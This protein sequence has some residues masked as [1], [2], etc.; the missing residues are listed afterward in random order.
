MSQER[1]D[2]LER[3]VADPADII[4]TPGTES[5]V[6]EIYDA[7]AE[8][9]RDPAN[10]DPQP[11]LRVRQPPRPL[12]CAPG[13]RSSA[14]SSTLRA[15][16]PRP[17]AR[18]PSSR[19]PARPARIARRRLPEGAARHADRRRRGARVPDD[20]RERLRRAQHPGHRRQAHPADP[21]RDEHR[22]R[23]RRVATGPP[24]SSTCCSTRD[25]GR[26]YLADR[27]RSTADV[28]D[29]LDALRALVDLQRARRDQDRQAPRPRARRRRS[30][31]SPPTARRMYGSERETLRR[32][33]LRRR[34]STRSTPRE[35]FGQHLRGVA[36]DH[37]LELAPRDR[38]RIFNLG[39]FTWVEQ[40]GVSLEDFDRRKDQDFWR[41]LVDSIPAWDGLIQD[42]N[43]EAGGRNA[44]MSACDSL[45]AQ[46]RKDLASTRPQPAREGHV[47]R[48]SGVFRQRRRLR[49][50]RRQHHV[51]HADGL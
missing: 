5:N 20:A 18:A 21:Q 41:S 48:G 42:F 30:S 22:R 19:P 46:L 2:W 10:V 25:A 32:A 49:R 36:D 50:H 4:R 39:Y 27:R 28:V 38:N 51:A 23:G 3:W 34:R 45:T 1:F 11:V 31:P 29:A 47:A 17:A 37:L 26:G 8:L 15:S 9:A 16:D 35:V 24:T 12:R 13:R 44:I 33:A 7:C 43:A 6:K 14:C 40:Q